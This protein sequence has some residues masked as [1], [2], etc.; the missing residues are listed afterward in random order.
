MKKEPIALMEVWPNRLTR[1]RF[2]YDGEVRSDDRLQLWAAL[3]EAQQIVLR[4]APV[5]LVH[6][7]NVALNNIW[8][9]AVAAWERAR[10]AMARRE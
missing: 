2:K 7:G 9:D 3:E 4:F 6:G 5:V 1:L 10:R 8:E